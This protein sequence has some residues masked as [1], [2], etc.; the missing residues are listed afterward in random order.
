MFGKP[1]LVQLGE[2]AARAEALQWK[3]QIRGYVMR[4]ALGA[5]AVIFGLMLLLA[6]HAVIY[7]ALAAYLGNL[8]AIF[9]VVGIDLVVLLILCRLATHKVDDPLVAEARSV[10]DTALWG[11]QNE[12]QTLGGLL[13]PSRLSDRPTSLK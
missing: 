6:I 3:R 8:G 12:V 9:A 7:S 13:E 4:T 2:A 10:R 1:R 11:A 5:T